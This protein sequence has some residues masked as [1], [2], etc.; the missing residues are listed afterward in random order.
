MLTKQKSSTCYSYYL[1]LFHLLLLLDLVT[2]HFV[3]RSSLGSVYADML[4]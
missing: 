4:M 3:L 1:L 2:E